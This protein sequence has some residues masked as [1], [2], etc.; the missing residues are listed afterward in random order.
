MEDFE[1]HESP[2]SEPFAR[3]RHVW[4]LWLLAIA[5][6]LAA[7]VVVSRVLLDSSSPAPLS[8]EASRQAGE[9][10]V[11][12]NPRSSTAFSAQRATLTLSGEVGSVQLICDRACLL[13][14]S[15]SYTWQELS[16]D[17]GMRFTSASG[18]T[19]E[20]RTRYVVPT[21]S[22]TPAPDIQ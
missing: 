2:A 14:G 9:L 17:I 19:T 5:A 7:G 15:I 13:R 10:V 11:R 21:S 3:W 16:V 20:E 12:W 22:E 8:L 18:D 6:G 4:L 1:T